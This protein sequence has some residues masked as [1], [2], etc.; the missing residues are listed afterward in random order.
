MGQAP[1]L[2]LDYGS[3][4]RAKQGYYH[5]NKCGEELGNVLLDEELEASLTGLGRC[6]TSG[7]FYFVVLDKFRDWGEQ[8]TLVEIYR[9]SEALEYIRA[10]LMRTQDAVAPVIDGNVS[11]AEAEKIK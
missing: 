6:K 7:G 11:L 2:F 9:A 1:L 8:E 10:L 5:V 3:G 4:V